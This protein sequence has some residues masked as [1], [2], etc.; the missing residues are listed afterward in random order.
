MQVKT[1]ESGNDV[2]VV[3]V[4]YKDTDPVSLTLIEN[5]PRAGTSNSTSI[6]LSYAQTCELINTLSR[7]DDYDLKE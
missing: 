1:I 2:L 6:M 3:H 4:G 7:G 5:Y